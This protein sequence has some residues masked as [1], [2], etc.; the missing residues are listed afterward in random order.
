M[1]KE[2]IYV[3]KFNLQQ[4]EE[5]K[6]FIGKVCQAVAARGAEL[7][8][9]FFTIGIFKDHV[10][11]R[12]ADSGSAFRIPLSQ[13]EGGTIHLKGE[14]EEVRSVFMPL[15]QLSKLQKSEGNI[16]TVELPP[17]FVQIDRGKLTKSSIKAIEKAVEKSKTEPS[18]QMVEAPQ[19]ENLW[20][21]VFE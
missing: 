13:S 2:K 8:K 10:I 5:L 16:Q 17:L 6:H 4:G 14:L 20:K 11:V 3:S 15:S 7:K 19:R 9:N 21:S 18:G 1:A 12:D